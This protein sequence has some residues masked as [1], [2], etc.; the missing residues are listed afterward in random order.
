MAGGKW[1]LDAP[2]RDTERQFEQGLQAATAYLAGR[3]QRAINRG[4]RDGRNPS[5]PGEP[6]KKVTGNL[7]KSV[8]FEVVTTASRRVI[9][10]RVGTNVVYGRYLELGTQGRNGRPGMAPRP[11]LRPTLQTEQKNLV[12]VIVNRM[13]GGLR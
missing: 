9:I 11:F 7:F 5:R 8:T 4:N 2:L 3:V 10:G 12:N 6:P 1:N 13:R